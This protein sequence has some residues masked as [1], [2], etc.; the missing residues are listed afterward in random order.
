MITVFFIN[1]LVF[2]LKL[3]VLISCF[4]P[5]VWHTRS[6]THGVWYHHRHLFEFCVYKCCTCVMFV[7]AECIGIQSGKTGTA[8]WA[9]HCVSTAPQTTRL[10]TSCSG[11]TQVVHLSVF[12]PVIEHIR[13]HFH[14][15]SVHTWNCDHTPL[16]IQQW[17]CRRGVVMP[18]SVV[19]LGD[20]D[21]CVYVCV[22]VCVCVC[23]CCAAC[24]YVCAFECMCLCAFVCVCLPS[25]SCYLWLT[26][27]RV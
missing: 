11:S 4:Q 17:F 1:I 25:F 6:R 16:N 23:V 10:H 24:V 3:R 7:S 12:M 26:P 8:W 18:L 9:V 22:F 2:V 20:L 5:K 14:P 27:V 21:K 19:K 13:E 15:L